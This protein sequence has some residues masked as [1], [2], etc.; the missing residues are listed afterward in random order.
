MEKQ[1][2]RF[3]HVVIASALVA[4]SSPAFAGPAFA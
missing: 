4:V 2:I 1:T 3:L